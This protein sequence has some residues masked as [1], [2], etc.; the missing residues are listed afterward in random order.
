[1]K[2]NLTYQIDFERLPEEI[3]HFLGRARCDLAGIQEE[4]EVIKYYAGANG[5]EFLKG[6]SNLRESLGQ[7]DDQ[8][9]TIMSIVSE[10]EKSLLQMQMDT[11]SHGSEEPDTTGAHDE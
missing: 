4:A 9:S 6:I 1:M 2:V 7:I 8:F 5:V 10:Y 11:P 3:T